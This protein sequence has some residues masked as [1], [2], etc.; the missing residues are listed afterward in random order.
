MGNKIKVLMTGAGAPGGPGIIKALLM[1]AKIELFVADMNEYATGK[2]LVSSSKFYVLPKATDKNFIPHLTKLCTQLAVDVLFPLV[3]LELFQL[4]RH[5]ESFLSY[6]FHVVVSDYHA[7]EIVNNKCKLYSHLRKNNI[8]TPN[9][10]VVK[11]SHC[12]CKAATELG[13]PKN[14][15]VIKPC[16]SN[17]S[18]GTRILDSRINRF[19][20]FLNHKPNSTYSSLNEIAEITRGRRI[21]PLMVSEYLPGDEITVDTIVKANK[22]HECIIRK[23]NTIA[24]G[25]STSGKF[26]KSNLVLEYVENIIKVTPGLDGPVGFQFKATQEGDYLL[27]ESNPRI[28]GTSVA[29]LGLGIN[30]PLMAVYSALG[31]ELS[32]SEYKKRHGISFSRY[33]SEVFYES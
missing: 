6:G 24:N 28:Q 13:Y 23:R 21:P 33:Y 15:I 30:L 11:D 7:I 9:Y 20:L 3:T 25:I 2:F 10:V 29:A 17:G 16:V 19:D 1:D 8:K 27:L 12:L 31:Y 5:K 4:S 26:I 22:L 14:P 18:R 32:Y